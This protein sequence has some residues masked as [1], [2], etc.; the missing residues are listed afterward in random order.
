[1]PCLPPEFNPKDHAL[2]VMGASKLKVG[3]PLLVQKRQSCQGVYFGTIS[4][5]PSFFALLVSGFHFFSTHFF[6][7]FSSL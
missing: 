2:E 5:V 3:T 1:M 6:F 7:L 4:K